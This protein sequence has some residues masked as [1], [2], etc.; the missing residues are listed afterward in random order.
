M[1][2]YQ[3]QSSH[4]DRFHDNAEFFP[5]RN[6]YVLP[7]FTSDNYI[8]IGGNSYFSYIFFLLEH[9]TVFSKHNGVFSEHNRVFSEHNRVFSQH[10]GVFPE[11]N[12]VFREH[13]A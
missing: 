1:A 10:N 5:E 9:N 12:E 6:F 7:I 8:F 2:E 4:P 11:H 3:L 13:N